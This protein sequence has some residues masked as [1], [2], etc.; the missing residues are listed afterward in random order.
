[1]ADL[2]CRVVIAQPQLIASLP[3]QRAEIL[4]LSASADWMAA[5]SD[6]DLKLPAR[7]DRPAYVIHTSGSTGRPKGT[8][9]S[10]AGIHNR[11]AWM[12]DLL[13]VRP[14]DRVLHKTAFGFDVS[15]WELLLPL[16]CGARIVVLPPGAQRDPAEIAQTI[17]REEVTI[18]HFVP[19]MLDLFVESGALPACPSLRH[20]VCSGE[21]LG[22]ALQRRFYRHSHAQLTNLYG[23][24]EAA[25]DVTFWSC[26]RQQQRPRPDRQ[27]RAQRE[28]YVLDSRQ[29]P[30][31]DG[32]VGELYI[33]GVQ[34]ASGYLNRPDESA[35]RF[36]ASPF[37]EGDRLYRTGDRVCHDESGNLLFLGRADDQIKIRGVRIEPDEVAAALQ[38]H[39]CVARAVV[40][41]RRD[42]VGELQLA[43][44][45][46]P[47]GARVPESV[48]RT[49][50]LA[51]LPEADHPERVSVDRTAAAHAQWQGRPG[52][53][54]TAF[55][56][57]V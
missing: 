9:N 7:A 31:P 54:G 52:S 33:G 18:A 30:V 5:A 44:Y 32:I 56:R 21:A 47:A 17:A 13:A 37:V 10:I 39:E 26:P 19:S 50:L 40:L 55:A 12:R 25:V 14:D 23:P 41:P 20:V 29:R 24:T 16:V 4:E 46:I 53:V 28:T 36:V 11:L 1:M 22:L 43:A 45:C 34:V 51:K 48:L 27:A 42:A 35:R 8:V 3:D 49:H 38:E 15:V 57:V 6:A 2:A